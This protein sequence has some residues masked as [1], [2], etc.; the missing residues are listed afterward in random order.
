MGRNVLCVHSATF[1]SHASGHC[2]APL[3]RK[4]PTL[5]LG[6]NREGWLLT[7]MMEVAGIDWLWQEESKHVTPLA[8]VTRHNHT[9]RTL[10]PTRAGCHGKRF[11]ENVS[12]LQKKKRHAEC[13]T[14]D[15]KI[16]HTPVKIGDG[17]EVCV[18]MCSCV[19]Y[20]ACHPGQQA[21]ADMRMATCCLSACR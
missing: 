15:T 7:C 10:M 11:L 3:L 12:E 9:A 6:D 4:K 19:N 20:P 14:L 1:C 17:M 16:S 2:T 18:K 8:P 13:P 21:S 5:G